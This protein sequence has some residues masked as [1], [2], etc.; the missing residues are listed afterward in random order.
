MP[1]INSDQSWQKI[2]R[3]ETMCKLLDFTQDENQQQLQIARIGCQNSI[4]MVSEERKKKKE[5]H[6]VH[7]TKKKEKREKKEKE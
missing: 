6:P 4:Q 3:Q 7:Q 2:S 1:S 5:N